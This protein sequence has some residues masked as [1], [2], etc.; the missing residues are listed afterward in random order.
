[1]ASR[2]PP[3]DAS[4]SSQGEVR[5]MGHGRHRTDSQ[6][7]ERLLRKGGG[8]GPLLTVFAVSRV[9]PFEASVHVHAT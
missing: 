6:A 9:G 2:G 4:Q 8:R 1:M 3:A 7:S 5:P